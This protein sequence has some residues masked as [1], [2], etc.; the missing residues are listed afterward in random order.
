MADFVNDDVIRL[1]CVSRFNELVDVVTT[2]TVKYETGGDIEFPQAS[3]DFQEYADDLFNPMASTLSDRMVPDRISVANLTQDTVFGS[4]AW[5]TYAG[6]TNVDSPTVPQAACLAFGRTPLSRV[7]IRKYLGVF[8]QGD[9]FDGV[10]VSGLRA[11][12]DT[13][14]GY[15]IVLQ[16]MSEGMGLRGCAYRPSDGRVTFAY[17]PATSAS[18]VI[19]RRRR[20]GAGS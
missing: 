17:S 10:W 9:E 4:I 2:L 16:T 15:H 20:V 3:L 12:C 14:M 11:V 7:Q 8:T 1:G 13:F 5:D 19:Q 6:G 18:V